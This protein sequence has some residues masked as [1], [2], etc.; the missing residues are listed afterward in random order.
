MGVHVDVGGLGPSR[1]ERVQS[2]LKPFPVW[3][4]VL[5]VLAAI[6]LVVLAFIQAFTL[7]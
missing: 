5:G 6:S 4:G 3:L 1:A 2:R 7:N